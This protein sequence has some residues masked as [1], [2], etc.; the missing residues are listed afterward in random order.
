MGIEPTLD[1]VKSSVRRTLSLHINIDSKLRSFFL[2]PQRLD[3]NHKTHNPLLVRFILLSWSAL[4]LLV[5]HTKAVLLP[6]YYLY[7]YP[8]PGRISTERGSKTNRAV[9]VPEIVNLSY[10]CHIQ[11][12]SSLTRAS[13]FATGRGSPYCLQHRLT[14]TH[15]TERA[16]SLSLF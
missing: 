6:V 2:Y 14:N 13:S 4:P 9:V 15:I 8:S 12:N 7:S 10:R 16:G 1:E 5:N 3:A 11:Y